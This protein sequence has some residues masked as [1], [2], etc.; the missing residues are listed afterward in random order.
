LEASR[1]NDGNPTKT[2]LAR[3]PAAQPGDSEQAE[4][5]QNNRGTTVRN[6]VSPRESTEPE[7]VGSG[8]G[9]VGAIEGNLGDPRPPQKT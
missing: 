9:G 2:S 7:L 3:E 4:T 1:S 6:A 8:K 5:N